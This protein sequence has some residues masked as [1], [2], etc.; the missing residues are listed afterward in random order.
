M[1]SG[2]LESIRLGLK[3]NRRPNTSYRPPLPLLPTAS[4]LLSNSHYG[5]F[6]L[7]Y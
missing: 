7:A 1:R 4:C 6:A 3:T 2:K 5:N